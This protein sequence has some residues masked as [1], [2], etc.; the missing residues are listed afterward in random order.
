MSKLHLKI[1]C[2]VLLCLICPFLSYAETTIYYGT[3]AKRDGVFFH[4][5][6]TVAI[7]DNG[8]LQM[9]IYD[10]P[11]FKEQTRV[12]PPNWIEDLQEGQTFVF[13]SNDMGHHDRGAARIALENF[14][15]VYGQGGGLQGRSYAIPTMTGSLAAIA[16]EVD[17]FI[18][19]AD[20]HPDLTFLVTRI[21]C[22]IAGW[23][24]ED[25][26]P[27]FARAYSLPNVYLPAEFWKVLSY[28]YS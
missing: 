11:L 18:M 28:K 1:V 20:S 3:M 4:S 26:A 8:W 25:I 22:G 16:R 7:T 23:R 10:F 24:D 21:G 2:I 6:S 13:G 19:F 5:K 12:P 15:A 17:E 9:S 27:L 14:G